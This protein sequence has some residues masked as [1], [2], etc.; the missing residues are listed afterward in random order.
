MWWL[1]SPD[2]TVFI[3]GREGNEPDPRPSGGRVQLFNPKTGTTA[4]M[5]ELKVPRHYHSVAVTRCPTPE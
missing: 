5:D 4:E 2:G 3:C 1:E